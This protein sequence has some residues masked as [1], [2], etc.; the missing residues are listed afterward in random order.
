MLGRLRRAL[1]PRDPLYR[2]ESGAGRRVVLVAK[3]AGLAVVM[4]A[5]VTWAI[6]ALSPGEMKTTSPAAAAHWAPVAAATVASWFLCL[7]SFVLG[8]Q[9]VRNEIA[10]D[11]A[12][13]LVMTPLRRT[14]LVTSKLAGSVEFLVIAALLLPLYLW[15]LISLHT[16]METRAFVHGGMYRCWMLFEGNWT[17]WGFYGEQ[18]FGVDIMAGLGGFLGDMAWYLLLAAVGAWAGAS[19]RPVLV[20]WLK[21]LAVA[22][23][24][25]VALTV[26]EWPGFD[27]PGC[28]QTMR[29]TFT[30]G[31]LERGGAFLLVY[32]PFSWGW[33][34]GDGVPERSTAWTA[35]WAGA[36]VTLRLVVAAL[37]IRLAAR[38]FDRIATD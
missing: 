38:R 15:T 9:S 8:L 25:L 33:G 3:I 29:E 5:H 18:S 11:T 24:V 6:L 37:F 23:G 16:H 36:S 7:L 35:L 32:N 10:G 22:G 12:E 2:R 28:A 30:A 4:A 34:W 31:S 1:L 17:P 19:R 26:L 27:W 14:R 13:A 20:V 21:G